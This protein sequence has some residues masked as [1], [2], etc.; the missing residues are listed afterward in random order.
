MSVKISKD[1]KDKKEKLKVL[2]K[3][4]YDFL[5][6][7]EQSKNDGFWIGTSKN[8]HL[9]YDD[10]FY[11]Y[12]ILG[13]GSL[14]LSPNYNKRIEIGTKDKSKRLFLRPIRDLIIKYNGLNNWA[15]IEGM[16]N[17]KLTGKVPFEFYQELLELITKVHE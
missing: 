12:I 2:A 3:S 4:A 11:C 16:S 14:E 1:Y 5:T 10:A 13:I 15:T 8:V 9:Y 6:L 7:V 17:I